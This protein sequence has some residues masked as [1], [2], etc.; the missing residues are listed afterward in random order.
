[1]AWIASV[2]VTGHLTVPAALFGADGRKDAL[3]ELT[4]SVLAATFI[5]WLWRTLYRKVA[6]L[7]AAMRPP[8]T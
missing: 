4:V 6:R 2:T 1:M 3:R 7:P 8:A 5:W